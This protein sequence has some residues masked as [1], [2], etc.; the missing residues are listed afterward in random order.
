MG[1]TEIL[2]VV[3]DVSSADLAAL[4]LVGVCF[5]LFAIGLVAGVLLWRVFSARFYA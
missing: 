3:G 5:L 4:E 2:E 1:E